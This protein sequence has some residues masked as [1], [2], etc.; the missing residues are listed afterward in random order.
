M[1]TR[2]LGKTCDGCGKVRV[3]KDFTNSK[4]PNTCKLCEKLQ[5]KSKKGKT[6]DTYLQRE[7]GITIEQY[8]EML[9]LQNHSCAICKIHIVNLDKELAVDHDHETGEVRELL[10]SNCNTALGLIKDKSWVAHRMFRYL[11]KHKNENDNERD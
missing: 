1:K 2:I 5:L 10:C 8:D 6:K 11:K 3:L 4:Y 7:Y 9:L